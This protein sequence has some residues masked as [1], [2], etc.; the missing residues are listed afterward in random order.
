[1]ISCKKDPSAVE[2]TQWSVDDFKFSADKN[3]GFFFENDT[4]ALFGAN[5]KSKDAI[6]LLFKS[7][8]A[9]GVYFVVNT[10]T[11]PS[12]QMYEDNECSMLIT[13]KT[14]GVPLYLCLVE[15][16]GTIDISYSGKKIIASFSNVKLGYIDLGSGDIVDATASG[17]IIEK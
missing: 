10:Q 9:A 14:G 15:D 17:T 3:G 7:K 5:S 13:N 2:G 16:A 4:S 12:T 8:P 6:I 11:K 1:L